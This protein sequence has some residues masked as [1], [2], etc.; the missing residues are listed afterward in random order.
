MFSLAQKI[1][2]CCIYRKQ[3]FL[4]QTSSSLFHL[5]RNSIN[6]SSC[7]L[8]KILASFK[9]FLNFSN[10]GEESSR[11][12]SRHLFPHP[13]KSKPPSTPL[14]PSLFRFGNINRSKQAENF[15]RNFY[16][17]SLCK[18]IVPARAKVQERGPPSP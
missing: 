6:L 2:Y 13:H 3:I 1:S 10:N 11:H 14:P 9:C 5:L 15:C 4:K 18:T 17:K 8:L 12:D 16:L 7:S